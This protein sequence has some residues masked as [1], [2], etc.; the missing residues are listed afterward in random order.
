MGMDRYEHPTSA[1]KWSN[2]SQGMHT[3]RV[4]TMTSNRE[5]RP[6]TCPAKRN[7]AGAAEG[8]LG[9]PAMF[10]PHPKGQPKGQERGFG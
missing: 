1:C 7:S 10:F 5:Y 6:T 4:L 3:C 8:D 9:P 2:L